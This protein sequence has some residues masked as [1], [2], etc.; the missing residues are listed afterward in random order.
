VQPGVAHLVYRSLFRFFTV[1][2]PAGRLDMSPF[3]FIQLQGR[4]IRT[5]ADG[6]Q[7]A[8]SP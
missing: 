4:P 1:F 6:S 8:T 3:R 7:T 5:F 2:G